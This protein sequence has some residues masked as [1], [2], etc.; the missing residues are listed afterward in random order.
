[1]LLITI[2]VVVFQFSYWFGRLPDSIP[3]HFDGNGQIDGEIS[4]ATFFVLIGFVHAFHLVG[5]PILGNQLKRVP[6][7]LINI[8]NKEHWLA[9]ERRAKT[10]ANT[11][12]ILVATGWMTSWL[13]IGITQLT[14]LVG[15]QA[16]DTINPEFGWMMLVYLIAT[17]GSLGMLLYS[18]RLPRKDTLESSGNSQLT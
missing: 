9:P 2:G 10:L 8:P 7:S 12:A 18:Y 17:F 11:S 5:F 6:D 3:S 16:R 4:K 13:F 14:A 1:M 15:I